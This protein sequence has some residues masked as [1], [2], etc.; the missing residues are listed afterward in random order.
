MMNI[1][2]ADLAKLAS[3]EN[4]GVLGALAQRYAEKKQL[5]LEKKVEN[6]EKKM[7][8]ESSRRREMLELEHAANGHGATA[9][10][11]DRL[12]GK[13][14]S[15]VFAQV[16]LVH[17]AE[18]EQTKRNQLLAAAKKE[19]LHAEARAHQENYANFVVGELAGKLKSENAIK[20][21]SNKAKADP[22]NFHVEVEEP[23]V[24]AKTANPFDFHVEVVDHENPF[25]VE[26][27]H[28]NTDSHVLSSAKPAEHL[29]DVQLN[30]AKPANNISNEADKFIHPQDIDDFAPEQSEVRIKVARKHEPVDINDILD[31][32]HAPEIKEENVI[33]S[34]KP[35]SEL[36][37]P[38][39]V[40]GSLIKKAPPK[41]KKIITTN[42]ADEAIKKSFSQLTPGE[43][44]AK[45]L[46]A[47]NRADEL[48]RIGK[49][50]EYNMTFDPKKPPKAEEIKDRRELL[51]HRNIKALANP[52][53][54]TVTKF[55]QYAQGNSP[56]KL[57]LLGKNASLLQL[58]NP[59]NYVDKKL[60]A[61]V[62]AAFN[63]VM[64]KPRKSNFFNV[65][66]GFLSK[67]KNVES[68]N[69]LAKAS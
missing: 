5:N 4:K 3:H 22:Y 17:N 18:L 58:N 29:Q 19:A 43:Q 27:P 35:L 12:F 55:S 32:K 65:I 61:E 54:P 48:T 24:A 20:L 41:P 7:L 50:T 68:Q 28:D 49:A 37:T 26:F 69:I 38:E 36:L 47:E 6:F 13:K 51:A 57:V 10:F 44:L 42:E 8:P 15:K 34:A 62:D 52:N 39:Y 11:L 56:K 59:R 33:T 40:P 64:V 60:S 25:H 21:N 45:Q 53:T 63:E 23:K 46:Y 1:N 9:G 66:K 16:D 67:P 14:L 31:G 2:T 30:A